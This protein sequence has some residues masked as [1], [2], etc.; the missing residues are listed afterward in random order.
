M[1][2][3]LISGAFFTISI[4]RCFM[5]LLKY[6][7][8]CLFWMLIGH[9]RT[10]LWYHCTILWIIILLN[11]NVH[12]LYRLAK[13]WHVMN[14]FNFNN[15][16]MNICVLNVCIQLRKGAQGRAVMSMYLQLWVCITPIELCLFTEKA[17]LALLLNYIVYCMYC[18]CLEICI[19]YWKTRF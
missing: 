14:L 11:S 12:M 19:S 2:I 17:S 9:Y 8:K 3:K 6:W 10:C 18:R 5:N 7:I 15:V 1:W 4:F 16:L 13:A